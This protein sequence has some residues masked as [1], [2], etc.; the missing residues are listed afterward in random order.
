MSGV[1]PDALASP[2]LSSLLFSSVFL[3]VLCGRFLPRLRENAPPGTVAPHRLQQV[4]VAV[5]ERDVAAIAGGMAE[6]VHAFIADLAFVTSC[7]ALCI[8]EPRQRL[9]RKLH[10]VRDRFKLLVGAE[11]N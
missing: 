3:R 10:R 4:A 11:V 6:V 1:L 9:L 7:R 8:I 5:G 2:L